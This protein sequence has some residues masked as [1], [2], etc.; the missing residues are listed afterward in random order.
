MDTA[1]FYS[2]VSVIGV[3]LVSLIGVFTLALNQ[4][5]LKQGLLYL[6]GFA[7]GALFG[8]AL[9]H[10][11]PEATEKFGFTLE[12]SLAV[13]AGILVMFIVEKIIHWRHCHYLHEEEQGQ[14]HKHPFAM[15][16]LVGDMVHNFID[17]LVIGAAYLVSVPVG[18]ATTLAVVF[19]EIPQE[20]GDFGVLL[21]GGFSVREAL[22]IN[23]LTALTAILG[24]VAVFALGNFADGL[25]FWLVPFA[26]GNFLY[27]A[28]SDLI[29]ELHKEVDSRVSFFQLVSVLLGI[30][31]M[32]LL[33]GLE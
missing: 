17:G 6:V 26:A 12:V 7:A 23:L 14:P 22:V 8:D 16:N 20:I 11:L 33:L 9:I 13:I 15:T 1:L 3:S 4:K 27:I 2:L 24:A 25:S 28:G 31:V 18:I 5:R 30:G 10:L 29:P 32:V 21:H 19:H